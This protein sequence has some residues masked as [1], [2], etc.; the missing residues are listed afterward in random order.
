MFPPEEM[1]ERTFNNGGSRVVPRRSPFQDQFSCG[2]CWPKLPF[3]RRICQSRTFEYSRKL[4]RSARPLFLKVGRNSCRA[5]RPRLLSFETIEN[6]KTL[7]SVR[8]ISLKRRSPEYTVVECST[9][10]SPSI[11]SP[12]RAI[13]ITSISD[14][15]PRTCSKPEGMLP[16]KA[17][18]SVIDPSNL[19]ASHSGT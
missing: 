3:S 9:S 1:R 16:L 13:H 19:P 12:P 2:V 17:N 11:A 15:I 14:K 10:K 8:C 18:R 6:R 7:G 5:K 4:V